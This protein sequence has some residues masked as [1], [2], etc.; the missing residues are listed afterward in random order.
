MAWPAALEGREAKREPFGWYREMLARGPLR[1][2]GERDCWD[3]FAYDAVTA[4]LEDPETFSSVTQP[5]EGP[6]GLPSMLNADPPAHT[7]LR[8]PVESFFRP[9][10]VRELA[11]EIESTAR[12][13]L[14][15]AEATVET[16]SDPERATDA[17]TG[18]ARFDVVR[19]LAVPLPIHT[20]AALLG[21]PPSDRDQFKAWSDEIVAGPQL[22]GGDLTT[23][24]A[25]RSDAA[26]ELASY[27][28]SVCRERREDPRDDLVSAV[29]T[30]TALSDTEVLGLLRLLLIAG[31]VTTTNAIA[32]TVW[33]LDESGPTDAVRREAD[34]I[35]GAIEETLRYRSP[36][37]RTV[38]RA[39]RA[40]ELC[41]RRI[42][43]D[44]RLAV[45][46]GA[47]NRDPARFD[48]P[49]S[50]RPDRSP[51]PHVAFG[52]GI[53][54][55]L[56]APL[57]RLEARTALRT[58]LERYDRLERVPADPDPVASPFIYGL[59]RLPVE[60]RLAASG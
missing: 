4:V 7:D 20:I 42:D 53:H 50:F 52:R 55:C 18:T 48:D 33:C 49:E 41:G 56:G 60:V 6:G 24:E 59:Q 58:L 21:V 28:A 38:R 17:G 2:D 13:L 12:S 15:E 1:Y 35:D 30:E 9:G 47:A 44:D 25:R 27:L 19:D 39:T 11:P 26:V 32:N 46:L 5:E 37:Q 29:L 51:N 45:W 8:Q 54:V 10:A 16:T 31:H 14:D 22:T 57:A 36:V 23:L 43:A 3:V 40:T 34:R